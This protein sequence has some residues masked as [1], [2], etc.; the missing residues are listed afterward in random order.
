MKTLILS[1]LSLLIAATGN[2]LAQGDSSALLDKGMQAARQGNYDGAIAAYDAA[3]LINDKLH[4]PIAYAGRAAAL[5]HKGE[6]DKAIADC[7]EAL[8]LQPA[9]ADAF[10]NRG[11][12]YY[13]KDDHG[14]AM[15]DYNEAIRLD[16]KLAMAYYNRGTIYLQSAEYDKAISDLNNALSLDPKQPGAYNNRGRVYFEK[17]DYDKAIAD[18]TG[19]IRQKPADSAAY[20]NRATAL[21]ARDD[22][23]KAIADLNK[24]ID[25]DPAFSSAYISRANIAFR[26]G[27]FDKAI[28]DFTKA[29]KLDPATPLVCTYRGTA[30]SAKGDYTKALADFQKGTESHSS[31]AYSQLAWLLATCPDAGI[32]DG[33]KAA[34]IALKAAEL[35]PDKDPELLKVLAAAAAE[36]GNFDEAVKFETRYMDLASSYD[37]ERLALYKARKPYHEAVND[38][39]DKLNEK[40]INQAWQ[41][42]SGGHT[43]EAISHLDK[44]LRKELSKEDKIRAYRARGDTY[45]TKQDYEKMIADY[46]EVLRLNPEDLLLFIDC[47]AAHYRAGRYRQ[48]LADYQKSADRDCLFGYWRLAHTYATCPDPEIRNGAKA[49]QNAL[50]AWELDRWE[51]DLLDTLAAAYAESGDFTKAIKFEAQHLATVPDDKGAQARLTLYKN[52]QPYRTREP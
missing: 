29:I 38:M 52:H 8:R 16:P 36:K 50:K 13:Y 35:S 33:S 49:V 43:D 4:K 30:Y 41:L 5:N 42:Q 6:Y 3:L 7:N 40:L 51:G 19:A 18:Y 45:K 28:A 24:A 26:L 44:I 15:K 21:D 48:A 39:R 1:S 11:L 2:V 9:Y 20:F 47:G 25:I 31:F 46:E 37:N 34:D 17:G 27:E 22:F 10:N 32:R 14:N 23:D 12:A